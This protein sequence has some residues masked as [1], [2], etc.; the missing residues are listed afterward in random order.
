MNRSLNSVL[1]VVFGLVAILWVVLTLVILAGGFA[2]AD[3]LYT[4]GPGGLVLPNFS[5]L[6]KAYLV[7]SML[8]P[9][10]VIGAIATA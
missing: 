10:V 7:S 8:M 3:P 9:F 5:L 4:A 6:G 2:G 1:L